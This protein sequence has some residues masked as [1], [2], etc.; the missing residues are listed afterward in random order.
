MFFPPLI[1][2]AC[3]VSFLP[4]GTAQVRWHNLSPAEVCFAHATLGNAI[5]RMLEG[6]TEVKA[7]PIPEDVPDRKVKLAVLANPNDPNLQ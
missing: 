1:K 6:Q 4:D 5:S 7:T 2:G 3:V